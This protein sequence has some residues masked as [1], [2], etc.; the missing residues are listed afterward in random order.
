MISDSNLANAYREA[1]PILDAQ[2]KAGVPFLVRIRGLEGVI[3]Q[4]WPFTREWHYLCAC[5]DVGLKIETCSGDA[6]CGRSKLHLP[7]DFGVPCWCQAGGRYKARER[8]DQT[9]VE[10]AAKVKKPTRFGR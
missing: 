6:T 7:H 4:F 3:R 10:A 5:N 2:K 9:A 8:T 1:L